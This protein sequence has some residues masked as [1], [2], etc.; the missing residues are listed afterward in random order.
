MAAQH[1]GKRPGAG[2]TP[3]AL[4]KATL[5][6]KRT[7]AELA[8][9]L[10]EEA[11]N[12]AAEIMR[13]VRASPSARI[14]AINTILDRGLGKAPQALTLKGPGGGPVQ[15]VDPSRMSTAALHEL[16]EAMRDEDPGADE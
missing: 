3:G 6:A 9:D 4:N 5:K 16:L 13:D 8:K 15:L 7:F 2:R 10:S 14:A 12:T 1:G 11:L